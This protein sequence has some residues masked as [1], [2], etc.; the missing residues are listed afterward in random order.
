[1]M[2]YTEATD[3][4]SKVINLTLA[5]KNIVGQSQTGTGKTAAFLIPLLQKID[6]NQK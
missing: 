6:T 1:M 5:G 3:I 2:K 4:Q